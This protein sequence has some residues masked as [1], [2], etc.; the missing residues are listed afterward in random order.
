MKVAGVM[1]GN[2]SSAMIEAPSFGL[3]AVNIGTR[4][5]GRERGKNI[6]DV[7]HNKQEIVKGIEKALTDDEFLKEVKKYKNPYGDGKTSQRIAEILSKVEITPQLL[8][9]KITY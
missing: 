5:E 6:I 7:R 3:P 2:S 8:Q 9:K 1:V 4:Q